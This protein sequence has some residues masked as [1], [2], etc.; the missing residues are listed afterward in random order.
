[1]ETIPD[2]TRVTLA[3]ITIPPEPSPGLSPSG[4]RETVSSP[5]RARRSRMQRPRWRPPAHGF[6]PGTRARA[7]EHVPSVS[8]P[9]GDRVP[10]QA[11][12]HSIAINPF[13][14]KCQGGRGA[15]LAEGGE[16]DLHDCC[17]NIPR[18]WPRS[19][20]SLAKK[21]TCPWIP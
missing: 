13:T 16:R 3:D 21:E 11:I 15:G 5:A 18:C 9:I 10:H 19:R 17:A 4:S 14:Y 1:M 12:C 20:L 7:S 6:R 2:L 8:S